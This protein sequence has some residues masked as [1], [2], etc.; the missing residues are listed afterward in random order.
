ME[1]NLSANH[2]TPTPKEKELGPPSPVMALMSWKH[3][4]Q[5]SV[6]MLLVSKS[7]DTGSLKIH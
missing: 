6:L 5:M 7:R 2:K 4:P 3:L 1:K